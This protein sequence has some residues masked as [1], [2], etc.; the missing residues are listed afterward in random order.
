MT[1][2]EEHVCF[3]SELGGAIS[4]WA[5]V[6]IGLYWIALRAIDIKKSKIIGPSFFAIENFRSKIA[7]V[8]AAF[9]AEFGD[10]K[11]AE[12]WAD[13]RDK[14]IALSTTRNHLVH[15]AVLVIPNAKPGRRYALHPRISK[16]GDIK[17]KISPS[18]APSPPVGSLFVRDI[19]RAARQFSSASNRLL[20][21]WYL[22]GGGEAFFPED[23][24]KDKPAP[25][26]AQLARQI[27][28]M[29]SPVVKSSRA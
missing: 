14:I 24:L 23:A 15:Y 28:A 18:A 16:P 29:L 10:G 6:E 22:L 1:P 2:S 5:H 20:N 7:F 26:V 8:D 12:E 27:R 11:F 4:Q 25:Q 3:Y 21:L 13:L 19:Y 9:Q 17:T